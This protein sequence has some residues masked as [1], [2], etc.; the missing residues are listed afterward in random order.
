MSKQQNKVPQGF[1]PALQEPEPEHP[2]EEELSPGE[3]WRGH[4]REILAGLTVLVLLA[5]GGAMLLRSFLL[6]TAPA[7]R[8]EAASVGLIDIREVLAAHP[9]YERL[10]A[11]REDALT[12]ELSLKA[13]AA[14]P[15]L[16]V[17]PPRTE[18]QPFED[19]VW[20][21]NA[22]T[23]IGAR[24]QLSR[25]ARA[26]QDRYREETRADYEARRDALDAEYLNA[27]LNLNL[28]LDNQKEMHHPWEKEEDL[29]AERA[30]W[31]AELDALKQERGARQR[32]LREEWEARIAAHVQQVMAPRI[33][34]WDAQSRQALAQQQSEA[35]AG[36]ARAQARNAALMEQQMKLSAEVQKHLQERELLAAD[37]QAITALE[38]HIY[39]DIAGKAAKIAILHHFELILATPMQNLAAIFPGRDSLTWETPAYGDVLGLGTEDVT[40]EL[41]AEIKTIQ[42]SAGAEGQ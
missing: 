6:D 35:L 22:Q 4:R 14:A 19:S 1:R 32:A 12:L 2:R 38:T 29:A 34:A 9:D 18:E 42:P 11:L 21:K 33:A 17:E 20:Q 26:E 13:R 28:K 27:I 31:E 8:Q 3:F 16:T 30:G 15:T 25:E 39:H 36:Q 5:A 10:Q 7:A 23:V 40:D 24:V 37:R 41:V